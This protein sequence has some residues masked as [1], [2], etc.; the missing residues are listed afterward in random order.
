MRNKKNV[1]VVGGA[2]FIGSNLSHELVKKGYEVFVI[3]SFRN[4]KKQHVP[5][6]ASLRVV[7][8]C[9]KELLDK[10]FQKIR[11]N[12]GPV[13]GV[14]HLAALPRVQFS[15]ENPIETSRVNV[16]GTVNVLHTSHNI[17]A[18][19]FI[20]SASSSAYGDQEVLPLHEDLPAQPKSPYG[21]QKYLG[22]LYARLWSDVYG[23]ETVSLRYFN[24]Y[25]PR[26]DPD[27][28]YALVIGKF[29]KQKKAGQPLTITGDGNQTRDFTHVS[30]V[31]AA[32][33]LALESK[34]VGK[35]EVINIGAGNNVS[36][37]NLA[38][39]MG[40]RVT[41]IPARIEPK[42]TKADN[43]KAKKLL[44]WKPKIGL[45]RGVG[46]LKKEWGF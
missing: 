18:R 12:Y 17:G 15:I 20:Y 9:D 31:V 16:L 8:I 44:N 11:K 21:L 4:G 1:I 39:L 5:K 2:G 27:G 30:D 29:L 6:E 25:G 23:L 37:N 45:E 40:G 14:F 28:P 26:L 38:K 10:I 3:D 41:Y 35:G 32:N 43:R 36:I 34:N 33:I 19:R 22:E 13:Y 7:D 24:V 46:L 42:H